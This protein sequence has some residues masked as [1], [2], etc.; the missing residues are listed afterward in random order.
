MN[1]YL[2]AKEQAVSDTHTIINLQGK[3]DQ[4][5]AVSVQHTAKPRRA[6]FAEGWPPTPEENLTRLTEAG[7]VMDRMV[8]KC[9]NCG[10]KCLFPVIRCR[11]ANP[12][13]Q[14]WVMGRR[15]ARKR[16]RRGRRL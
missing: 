2:I 14:N 10:R 1:T 15:S 8:P 5:Y 9:G 12:R 16:S 6:K 3:I 7:F 13:F 11:D 4:K